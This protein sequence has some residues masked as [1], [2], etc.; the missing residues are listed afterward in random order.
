MIF[1]LHCPAG[2]DLR[3]L[4]TWLWF[5]RSSRDD[6]D[7]TA[8]VGHPLTSATPTGPNRF[9]LVYTGASSATT[10][11]HIPHLRWVPPVDHAAAILE[12]RQGPGGR[13]GTISASEMEQIHLEVCDEY[14]YEPIGWTAV[15]RELRRLLGG[16][17]NSYGVDRHGKRVRA[18]RI[19][20]ADCLASN[21]PARIE[22]MEAHRRR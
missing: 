4:F 12:F 2:S 8:P 15:G 3:R 22:A 17:R 13:T 19:A 7:T 18:Y 21:Q 1:V 6:A 14:N 9:E 5:A 11:C 10:A 20:P 16:D